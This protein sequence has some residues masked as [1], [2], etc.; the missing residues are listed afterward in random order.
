MLAPEPFFQPRGTPISVYFR[1]LALAELGHEVD[2]VTY[3]LGEDKNFRN[4]KIHR[5]PSIFFIKKIKVGPSFTKIPL[6]LLLL[7]KSIRLL[8]S[9]RYDIIFSHE[10]A[11]WFGT[12]LAK[13]KKIPHLYDM[14]SSLPQQLENFRFSRSKFLKS[15]FSALERYV[16]R[17]SQSIIVICMDLLQK[18]EKEK[19][20]HKATLIENFLDF[21]HPGYSESRIEQERSKFAT[22]E[23]KIVLYTGNFED[24]QGIPLFL[25]ACATLDEKAAVFLLVGGIPSHVDEMK[26]KASELSISDRVFFTG[27]VAPSEVPLYIA[28]ADVLVSPRTAGTNTPLKIYSFLKSGKPIVA[29]NLWTHSQ[30]LNGKIAVLAQPNPE[31]FAQGILFALNDKRAIERAHMARDMAEKDYTM[32]NYNKKMTEALQKACTGNKNKAS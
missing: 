30:V 27:Q 5:I 7:C 16:L 22:P 32:D 20:N 6:D 25:D 8:I 17:N 18:L 31:S 28:M 24:Y 4:L 10:E 12:A 2:L 11:S 14:H 19:V 3:H 15:I 23:Q 21:D 9:K 13:L 1:L 26:K 29:T